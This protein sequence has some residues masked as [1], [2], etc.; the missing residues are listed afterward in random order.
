MFE[1]CISS[2]MCHSQDDLKLLAKEGMNDVLKKK[3]QAHAESSQIAQ[4][5]FV[6]V[7]VVFSLLQVL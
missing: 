7:A 5:M 1:L 4:I 2:H 6:L 3:M